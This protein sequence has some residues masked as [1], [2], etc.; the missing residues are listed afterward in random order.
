MNRSQGQYALVGFVLELAVHVCVLAGVDIAG[1]WPAVWVLAIGLFALSGPV[2]FLFIKSFKEGAVS[3][4]NHGA[5][6]SW[7]VVVGLGLFVYAFFNGVH[8][9]YNAM[10]EGNPEFDIGNFLTMVR[11]RVI[12]VVALSTC[13]ALRANV[14][15]ACSGYWLFFYFVASAYFAYW[16]KS[17]LRGDE[18]KRSD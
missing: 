12:H 2:V 6:P 8:L 4:R 11:G 13:T 1:L 9:A 18:S 15:R 16:R 5:I 14:L 3:V 10:V 7:V 17:E